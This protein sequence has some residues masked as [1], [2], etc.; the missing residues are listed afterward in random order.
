MDID[1]LSLEAIVATLLTADRFHRDLTLRYNDL[2]IDSEDE[3][4]Y[5]N[6][7]EKL[8]KRMLSSRNIGKYFSDGIPNKYAFHTMLEE[9]LA[10]IKDVRK[11][12]VQ[13]RKLIANKAFHYTA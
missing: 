10:Q 2:V 1:N 13:N 11:T 8:T 6:A 9:I 7:A 5:L 3:D 12:P 4:A